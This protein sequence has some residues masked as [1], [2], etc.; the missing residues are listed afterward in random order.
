MNGS[1]PHMV[2]RLMMTQIQKKDF[3]EDNDSLLRPADSIISMSEFS[4]IAPS[5]NEMT[6]QI[7]MIK[8]INKEIVSSSKDI[9]K[10]DNRQP[11]TQAS[12]SAK[13]QS[14][15]SVL[16]IKN[17]DDE[18]S[19]EHADKEKIIPHKESFECSSSSSIQSN[20]GQ[21]M[22]SYTNIYQGCM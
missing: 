10:Y 18:S 8:T 1:S 21:L 2:K 17:I 20:T 4:E 11:P 9:F 19:D 14:S 6:H 7:V 22:V 3:V 13:K 12:S 15:P 16:N 5:F